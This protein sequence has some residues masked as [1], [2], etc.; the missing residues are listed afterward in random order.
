MPPAATSRHPH[1]LHTIRCTRPRHGPPS[2][3]HVAEDPLRA[4]LSH[5]HGSPPP[6][7]SSPS[8][9]C[10]APLVA[11][12][13]LH[14]RVTGAGSA[15]IIVAG[16]VLH[17]HD[18]ADHHGNVLPRSGDDRDGDGAGQPVGGVDHGA[19]LPRG[20]LC[21][22]KQ[23]AA[24][25]RRPDLSESPPCGPVRLLSPRSHRPRSPRPPP[26]HCRR[27]DRFHLRLPVRAPPVT[28]SCTSPSC[29]V[30]YSVMASDRA[31]GT[32]PCTTA[33]SSVCTDRHSSAV[34]APVRELRP[35]PFPFA[36]TP[37]CPS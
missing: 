13:A 10:L 2:T 30:H 5:P 18:D 28:G 9:G 33:F 11:G 35:R 37:V 26:W 4:Y 19:R 36:H 34:A 20:A 25:L 27:H 14:V 7:A 8:A 1:S 29:N 23:S 32:V 31:S 6:A 3:A 22:S 17:V 21:T 24:P 12:A 16:D 15:I